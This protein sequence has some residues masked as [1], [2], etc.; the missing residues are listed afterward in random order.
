MKAIWQEL[1]VEELVVEELVVEEIAV[2]CGR[3]ASRMLC[4][5]ESKN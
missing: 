1:V 4:E 5:S 3:K 2:C